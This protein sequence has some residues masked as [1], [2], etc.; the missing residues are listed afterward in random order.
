MSSSPLTEEEVSLL[1]SR[2]PRW[3]C[4]GSSLTSELEF[5]DFEEAFKF[6]TSVAEIAE[7]LNHHP[8]W[9]N[10]WN[11][12]KITLTTHSAGGLTGLDVVFVERVEA[13]Q[14]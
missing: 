3:V 12:V 14:P 4:D 8:D 6:M 2:F 1:P 5:A 9:S 11:R 13:L 10:S 7:D